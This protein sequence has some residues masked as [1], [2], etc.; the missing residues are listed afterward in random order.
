M[1]RTFL[2]FAIVLAL[3]VGVPALVFGQDRPEAPNAPLDVGVYVSPPFVM[4][5][6]GGYAGMAVDLWEDVAGHLGLDFAYREFGTFGELVSAAESGAVDVAVTN[7]TITRDR[8]E[9]IEFTHPWFDAGLRLLVHDDAG[10]S[11]NSLIRGLSDSGHLRAYAWI[12]IVIV[13]ATIVLTLFDRR[14]DKNFPQRW[15]DGLAESFYIVMSVATSGRP[16]SRKNLF[17]WVGRV[18]QALWL[19]CGV[20]VLA[21]VTSSVTSVMTTL[22]LTSQINSVA[23][24]PGRPV[25]VLQGSVAERYAVNAGLQIVGFAHVE[26]AVEALVAD[27]VAAIVADAPVLEYFEHSRPDI[28]VSVVGPIFEPDKYGFGLPIGSALTR[29]LSIELIGAHEADDIEAIRI[30]YFGAQ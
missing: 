18:W 5:A 23:D 7:L 30:R 11:F 21:Y 8:A 20:A 12:A 25:A 24:L 28:P 9:R 16:P 19:M 29:P 22:S 1:L 6:E 4:Q 26:D 13:F 10:T 27:R 2:R 17:G 15:P 14:F 3:F